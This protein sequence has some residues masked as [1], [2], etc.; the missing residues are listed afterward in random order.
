MFMD[1]SGPS[2]ESLASRSRPVQT[3][4]CTA[5][6]TL[7]NNDLAISIKPSRKIHTA[8]PEDESGREHIQLVQ[9]AATYPPENCVEDGE[10]DNDG[11]S[12]GRERSVHECLVAIRR[13]VQGILQ[14]WSVSESVSALAQEC[15]GAGVCAWQQ[16][17]GH[18]SLS[19]RLL[20]ASR[21]RK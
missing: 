2:I 5:A 12:I 11:N 3:S 7:V 20:R 6:R 15:I 17:Q 1:R 13:M 10:N 18:P 4:R 9:A 19:S 14:L 8:H 16:T 21:C